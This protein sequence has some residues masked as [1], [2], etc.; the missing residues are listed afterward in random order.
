VGKVVDLKV[1]GVVFCHGLDYNR[2]LQ[3]AR[4]FI[5]AGL[6]KLFCSGV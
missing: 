1:V 6:V 3:Q 5:F 2:N 4:K